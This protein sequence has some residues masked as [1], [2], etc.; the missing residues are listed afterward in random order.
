V[1]A[2]AAKV[3]AV[4]KASINRYWDKIIESN[5]MQDKIIGLK[6]LL[7]VNI[8]VTQDF[9]P[10]EKVDIIVSEWMGNLLLFENVIKTVIYAR[11]R[12][13]KPGGLMLPNKAS[14]F[15]GLANWKDFYYS[16]TV[17]IF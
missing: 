6:G 5:G 1:E 2:G 10:P 4:D 13:L 16:K 15:I 7:E 14:I 17:Y 3:Y 12:W 11:D 9:E 8:K